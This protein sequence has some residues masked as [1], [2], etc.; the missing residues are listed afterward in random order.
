MREA[1]IQRD[2]V[3]RVTIKN[4]D[5]GGTRLKTFL[6]CTIVKEF[7]SLTIYLQSNKLWAQNSVSGQSLDKLSKFLSFLQKSDTENKMQ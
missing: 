4:A 3:A 1:R 7:V 6:Y 2:Q 5:F